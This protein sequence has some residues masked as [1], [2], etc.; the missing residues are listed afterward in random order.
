MKYKYDLITIELTNNDD[1]KYIQEF[2]FSSD[3]LWCNSGN[4]LMNFSGITTYLYV[5]LNKTNELIEYSSKNQFLLQ[6][7]HYNE[8][9]INKVNY[10]LKIYTKEDFNKVKSIIKFGYTPS[11]KPKRIER[12]I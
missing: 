1:F 6:N 12:V 11:Y 5:I 3:I 4:R 8:K 2:M 9:F 7:S 10:D